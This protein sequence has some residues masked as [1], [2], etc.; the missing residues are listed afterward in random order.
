M[1]LEMTPDQLVWLEFVG[2]VAMACGVYQLL[3]FLKWFF[4]GRK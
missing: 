1:W 2:L 3:V 4:Q